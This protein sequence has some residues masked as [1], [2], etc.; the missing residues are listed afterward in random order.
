MSTNN[1]TPHQALE[2][3]NIATIPGNA[4]KLSRMDYANAETAL[5]VL[6]KFVNDHTPKTE[7]KKE[8]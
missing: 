8:P 6:L 2:V 7:E 5:Q 3:L 4:G 1:M